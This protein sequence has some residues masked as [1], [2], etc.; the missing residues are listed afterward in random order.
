MPVRLPRAAGLWALL[1]I[2]GGCGHKPPSVVAKSGM[3]AVAF[4]DLPSWEESGEEEFAQALKAFAASCR[5]YDEPSWR[6]ICKAAITATAVATAT[7]ATATATADVATAT[8]DH[9]GFFEEN[10]RPYKFAADDGLFTGYY[11]PLF[12]AS[13]VRT[14][15]FSAP[16]YAPPPSL[17]DLPSRA[18][19][20]AYGLANAEIL[21]WLRPVDGF[22]LAIQGSGLLRLENGET[23]RARFA[24]KNGHPYKSIGAIYAARYD[25]PPPQITAG[26]LIDFITAEP[27]RGR[28]LM[29]ENPSY[30]FFTLEDAATPLVGALR[31]P[32]LPY[33][34]MA[35]DFA[36]VPRFAPLWLS[37]IA[38]DDLDG[39]RFPRL[40]FAH[41]SGSAIKGAVR[42]DIFIGSGAAAA[43][44][45]G[46]LQN[47]GFYYLL[48]PKG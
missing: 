18:E 24:A 16:I 23:I 11:Q 22:F 7:V 5:H 31:V 36:H 29:E 37:F 10:F 35:V 17:A 39:E 43:D 47:R 4:A 26:V 13:R 2:V 40:V 19:I 30:V 28:K 46:N 9:R 33:R 27:Q 34:S 12:S 38:V 42:G 41:D 3:T 25:I 21:A 48:L 44:T 32:L 1:L 14:A 20:N 45:A 8:A 6:P 15:T